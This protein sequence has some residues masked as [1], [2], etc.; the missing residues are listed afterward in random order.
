VVSGSAERA[1]EFASR[2]GIPHALTRE[3]DL[4]ALGI[5][6]VYVSSTNDKHEAS[7]LHAASRGWHVLCEK[8]L[9]TTLAAAQRMVQACA[10]AGGART[11]RAESASLIT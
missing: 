10:A 2:F 9:A 7:V 1:G 3:A 4:A 8:P 11:G 6:A 5:D